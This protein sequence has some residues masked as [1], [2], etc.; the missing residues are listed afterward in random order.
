MGPSNPP[1]NGARSGM[2]AYMMVLSSVSDMIFK[3]FPLVALIR[4]MFSS[5]DLGD[6][7][8]SVGCEALVG[9]AE[10]EGTVFVISGMCFSG[11]GK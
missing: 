10:H 5:I 7:G 2:V 8:R 1:V 9:G 6:V 4:F 3:C 11:N